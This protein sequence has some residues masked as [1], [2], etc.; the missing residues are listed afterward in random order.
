[1][2]DAT[3]ERIVKN[4]LTFREANE[5]IRAR[6]EEY[7]ALAGRIPFLCE[8]ARSDCVQIVRLTVSEYAAVRANPTHFFTAP[9]H[10]GAEKPVGRQV[11]HGDGHVV[12]EKDL[13][14]GPKG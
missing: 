9:G 5:Q 12:V 7:D 11:G 10:E 6:A 13:S 3:E 8:C 14:A 1:M 2:N 4:N